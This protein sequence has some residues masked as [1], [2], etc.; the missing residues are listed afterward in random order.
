MRIRRLLIS[1]LLLASCSGEKALKEEPKQQAK[2]ETIEVVFEKVP[3]FV[4][5]TGY[6]QPDKEGTVKI[7]SRLAGVVQSIKVQVGDAVKRGQVLATVKAPDITD[8]YSQ[9][10]SLSAQLVQAERLYRLKKELYEVGAISKSELMD[11]ET[12]Y[13]II[14]AQ[15]EG[16][17]K[18]LE[19]LGGSLGTITI[20]SPVD[21]V[22]YQISA[23][24]GDAVDQST[25]IL[26]IADP[27][28]VMVVA[29]LPDKDAL[30][31]KREDR[32]EFFI[33][34]YPEKRFSGTIKYVSDVVDPDTRTVKVF[35][36]PFEKEPF[37]INMFFNI[38]IIIGQETYAVVPKSAILY[39]DGKFYV[40]VLK[41]D[42]PV[43]EEVNFI[44]EL[45]DGRV[46]LFG[47]E[48]GQKV[49]LNPIR[50]VSP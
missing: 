26:S 29:L 9:K 8:L 5:A 47:L 30:R 1:F 15:L 24:V 34:T 18:K 45:E 25:E 46:A 48:K 23:H 50:E 13:K 11:A 17:Q 19:L 4:E 35:I 37:K 42:K 6:V 21:G 27:K 10:L 33:S 49:L 32:A 16:I 44:K 36:E 39:Q 12:N 14:K 3:E 41:D 38:K 7:T 31:V 2:R 40:Y 43:K 28:K 22:V 20:T